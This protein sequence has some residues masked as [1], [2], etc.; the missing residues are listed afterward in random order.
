M[1]LGPAVSKFTEGPLVSG[2]G[3]LLVPIPNQPTHHITLGLDRCISKELT[4]QEARDCITG[5]NG[6]NPCHS[7]KSK[8][9]RVCS[10]ITEAYYSVYRQLS[11]W[12]LEVSIYGNGVSRYRFEVSACYELVRIDDL[13]TKRRD[14]TYLLLST[15]QRSLNSDE[16]QLPPYPC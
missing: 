10:Q 11:S 8:S 9:T 6:V 7:L 14:F 4:H 1:A 16:S 13:K 3:K 2:D 15:N 5:M 12:F